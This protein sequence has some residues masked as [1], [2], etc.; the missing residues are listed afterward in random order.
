M[1]L[2][3]TDDLP[4]M[5]TELPAGRDCATSGAVCTKGEN[6]RR[7]TNSPSAQVTGPPRRR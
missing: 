6:R 7:L 5:S 2:G 4:D 3:E 1:R